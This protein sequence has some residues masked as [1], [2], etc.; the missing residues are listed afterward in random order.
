MVASDVQRRLLS[1]SGCLCNFLFVL[2]VLCSKHAASYVTA[3][4]AQSVTCAFPKMQL[5][6]PDTDTR[7]LGECLSSYKMSLIKDGATLAKL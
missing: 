4:V 7:C 3:G 6:N 2:Y 5:L 1:N